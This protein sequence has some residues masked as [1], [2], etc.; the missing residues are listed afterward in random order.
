MACLTG[1]RSFSKL[2]LAAA[3]QQMLLDD[4]SARLVTINTHQGLYECNRL[5]FGV[6]SAPAVFQRAMDSIPFVI[7][8]LDDI[9]VTG[10]SDQEH[11]IHLE[12]VF[13]RLHEHGIRLKKDKC[14]FFQSYVEY[15]GHVID[16]RG[17]HTSEKKV[18]AIVEAPAPQNLHE[19]R[20]F[21]GLL[22]YYAKFL[23][24]LASTLHPLH[25]LLRDDH[26]WHWFQTAKKNL[27]Q[28]PVLAHCSVVLVIVTRMSR[29]LY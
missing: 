20:S 17:V 15:L 9:L 25:E 1:G 26:P 14:H 11:L 29:H 19:L 2:D 16:A 8:Y 13:R 24:N 28:A 3:Y 27:V 18:Q 7:C 22:N 4:E 23:P 10:R 6:A 21:L 5:P 12:E